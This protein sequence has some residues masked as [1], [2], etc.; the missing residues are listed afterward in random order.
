MAVGLQLDFSDLGLD[1]YDKVCEAL[2]FPAQWPDGLL[3]HAAMEVDGRLRVTDAWSSR[4]DFDR[5]VT[6]RL[7]SAVGEAAGERAQEPQVTE[8]ALHSFHMRG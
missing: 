8:T 6:E 2:D 4:Q 5:F 1:D 3:A 7:Q